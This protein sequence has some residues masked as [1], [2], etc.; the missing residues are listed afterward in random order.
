[1]E[2]EI[3]IVRVVLS[4]LLVAGLIGLCALILKW[5]SDKTLLVKHMGSQ[6]RLR[7]IERLSLDAKHRVFLVVCDDREYVVVSNGSE[8][9]VCYSEASRGAQAVSGDALLEDKD[10]ADAA[11]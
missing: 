5:L 7:L 2:T 10:G 3:N 8:M 9:E 1:M 6:R 4:L 11:N